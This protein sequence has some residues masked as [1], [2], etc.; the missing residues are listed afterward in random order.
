MRDLARR[1]RLALLLLAF[2]ALAVVAA[3]AGENP[4]R[5]LNLFARRPAPGSSAAGG[6]ACGAGR[7]APLKPPP[8]TLVGARARPLPGPGSEGNEEASV[9][10]R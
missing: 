2:L 7:L 4:L 1:P 10:V 8:P 3:Y 6:G 5:A 9:V